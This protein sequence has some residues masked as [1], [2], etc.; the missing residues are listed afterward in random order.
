MPSAA[1]DRFTEFY[2]VDYLEDVVLMGHDGPGCA[3][4]VS[5]IAMKIDK[6]AALL[7]IEHLHV[8]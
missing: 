7:G 4:G 5:H 1:E 2:A 3:I 8:C 6:L